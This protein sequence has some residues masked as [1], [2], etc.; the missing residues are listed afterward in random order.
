MDVFFF[1]DTATTEIYTLSLHDALPIWTTA[2]RDGGEWVIDG[3]KWFSSGADGAAFGVV[4]AVTDPDAE[5]HRRASQIIV[6]A[7]TPGVDVVRPI[8]VMGHAGTGWSTHCEVRYTGVRVPVDNT[9]G[10]P[11]DGFRIAQKR[12]GPGRIHHVMRWL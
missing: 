4:M 1:N 12:I 10:E 9:L 6:S 7:D 8:P 5:P 2:R 11:G 3:H